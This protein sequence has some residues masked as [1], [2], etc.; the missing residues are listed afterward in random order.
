MADQHSA[1]SGGV[2]GVTICGDCHGPVAFLD[3]RPGRMEAL[4]ERCARRDS[5]L[6]AGQSQAVVTVLGAAVAIAA[7]GGLSRDEI[8]DLAAEAFDDRLNWDMPFPDVPRWA[9]GLFEDDSRFVP[10]DALEADHG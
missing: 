7:D 9:R 10:L 3:T 5:A 8:L 2:E 1:A 6:D 4:C